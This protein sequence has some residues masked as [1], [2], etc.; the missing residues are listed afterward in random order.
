M[1]ILVTNGQSAL[2]M[3]HLV[4]ALNSYI[5]GELES[6]LN[7]PPRLLLRAGRRGER[8]SMFEGTFVQPT[9]SFVG[10]VVLNNPSY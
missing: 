9:H 4:V 3:G 6:I 1:I 2:G 5:I 8:T 7:R 10:S